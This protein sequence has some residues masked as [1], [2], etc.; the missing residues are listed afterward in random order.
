MFWLKSI[1]IKITVIN[2]SLRDLESKLNIGTDMFESP[3]LEPKNI[4]ETH[5]IV[6]NE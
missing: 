4:L 6:L 3:A 2:F 5:L 1:I